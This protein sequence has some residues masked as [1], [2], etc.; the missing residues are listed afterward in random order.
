VRL[1]EAIVFPPTLF[2]GGNGSPTINTEAI[3]FPPTLF[4][5]GH[6]SPTI[7]T[8]AIVFPPT[9]FVGGTGRRPRMQDTGPLTRREP[10]SV[11]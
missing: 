10:V 4:V 9:P 7:N 1:A 3:V 2:V 5:G 6:G 8:E 11:C